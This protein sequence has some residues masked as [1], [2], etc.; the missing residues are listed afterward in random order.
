[1]SSAFVP[2]NGPGLAQELRVFKRPKRERWL[3]LRRQCV[4]STEMA[5]VAGIPKYGNT[6]YSIY[7]QRRFRKIKHLHALMVVMTVAMLGL[8][9]ALLWLA[10][11]AIEVVADRQKSRFRSM[12]HLRSNIILSTTRN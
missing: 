11:F 2:T 8:T 9:R 7:H 12:V 4:T 5:P 10:G 6:R 3:E 1:M